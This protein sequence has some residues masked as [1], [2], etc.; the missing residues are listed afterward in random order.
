MSRL[1]IALISL[2]LLA[3]C[4]ST[5]SVTP[6]VRSE[7]APS[8]KLRVGIN[9]GNPLF[10]KRDRAAKA[11]VSPSILPASSAAGWAYRSSWSA[12]IPGA[13]RPRA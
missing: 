8:G 13:R 6:Q 2:F 7:L 3:S 11:A 1:A 5:P 4:A 12:T 10:A 9:Y